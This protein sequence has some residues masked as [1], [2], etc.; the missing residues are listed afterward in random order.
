MVNKMVQILITTKAAKEMGR[1]YDRCVAKLETFA[2]YLEAEEHTKETSR[3]GGLNLEPLQGKL[4][5]L[6][7]LRYN[8]E[9]R[10]VLY[11][12][13]KTWFVVEFLR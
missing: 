7:S 12:E 4:K 6:R 11:N 9:M 5:K 13:G 2:D 3:K 1:D 10:F 8:Q